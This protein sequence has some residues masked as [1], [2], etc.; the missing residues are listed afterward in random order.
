[1]TFGIVGNVQKKELPRVVKELLVRA[2]QDSARFFVSAP[3]ARAS[4]SLGRGVL[5]RARVVSDKKILEDSDLLIALGGD[6]TILETARM[7]GG[8]GTP[9]LGINL[10]KLGF[11]AE[12]SLDE[13]E[14]CL[15]EILE[16]RYRVEER[17]M[18]QARAASMKKPFVAL[19]DIVVDKYGTSRVMSIETMVNNEYLATYSADGIIVSTPTGSTAY[20]LANGGP[21]VTP[22]NHSVTISPICPHTLTARPVIVPDDSV[23]AIS[24]PHGAKQVHLTA[25]GQLEQLFR[26][27]VTIQIR[28]APFKAKLVK[29]LHVSYYDVLR[30]KLH[31]GSDV[32]VEAKRRERGRR[33]G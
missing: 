8:R 9:I 6:G 15:Q 22:E 5:T 28:K 11:L 12:V 21:I 16:G 31:W 25:D 10:G 30:K 32:R 33:G 24:I 1:M 4:S 27:P 29:R 13:V 7:V 19:N 18:L 23:I 17:M 3:V 14:A 2:P 20:A 26:P